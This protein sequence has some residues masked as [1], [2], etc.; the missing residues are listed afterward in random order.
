M[1]A[2][3]N[4]LCDSPMQRRFHEEPQVEAT[5]RLLH[6]KFPRMWK[7]EKIDKSIVD[8][9][10]LLSVEQKQ[11]LA[12]ASAHG[13]AGAFGAEAAPARAAAAA[14]NKSA[15]KLAAEHH[16]SEP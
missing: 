16:R 5:E 7:L 3:A 8:A 9:H 11:R 2:V 14:A 4:V 13:Q 1:L 15:V 6:E 12:E 10:A